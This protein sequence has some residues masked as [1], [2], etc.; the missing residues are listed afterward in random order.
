MRSVTRK[1]RAEEAD[2]DLRIAEPADEGCRRRALKI[3]FKLV[4]HVKKGYLLKVFKL[5]TGDTHKQR[6]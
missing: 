2:I 5:D 3:L 6:C 4:L 1:L